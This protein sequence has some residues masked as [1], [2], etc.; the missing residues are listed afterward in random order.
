MFASA[1]F[2]FFGGGGVVA[3]LPGGTA[4]ADEPGNAPATAGWR[5]NSDGTVDRRNDT[6]WT[7]AVHNWYSPTQAAIGAGYQMRAT[8]LS[9]TTPDTGVYGSWQVMSGSLTFTDTVVAGVNLADID[10]EISTD[11]TDPGIVTSGIYT[12]DVLSEP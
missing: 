9:G 4:T 3:P 1:L 8:V 2:M 10:M 5:F 12:I 11:G 6:G 7:L